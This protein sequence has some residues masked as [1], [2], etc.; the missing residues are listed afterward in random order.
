M[1]VFALVFLL[2]LKYPTHPGQ[3]LITNLTLVQSLG[4]G[5]I[6][7]TCSE[8][9]VLPGWSISTEAGAYL[10][11]PLLASVALYKSGRTAALF[12][13]ACAPKLAAETRLPLLWDDKRRLLGFPMDS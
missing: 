8:K 5:L 11:F 1:L 6:C 9:P 12:A 13:L 3:A 2:G 4:S 7:T 10:L